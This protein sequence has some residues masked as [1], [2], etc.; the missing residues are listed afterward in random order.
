[1]YVSVN[2]SATVYHWVSWFC[3]ITLMII[4]PM[5][6]LASMCLWASAMSSRLNVLSITGLKEAGWSEKY[7][8]TLREKSSTRSAL[9]WRLRERR[10]LVSKWPRLESSLPSRSPSTV[11][12]P[13][14]PYSTHLPSVAKELTFCSQLRPPMQSRMTFAPLPVKLQLLVIQ[15]NEIFNL[16]PRIWP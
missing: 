14:V 11:L 13:I 1:M 5:F 15:R 3:G 16:Q 7:G 12:P 9:Y 2:I 8:N 4:F 10:R 6:L